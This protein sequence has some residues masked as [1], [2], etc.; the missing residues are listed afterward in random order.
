PAFAADMPVRTPKPA[1]KAP[2]AAPIYN[3]TGPYAGMTVGYGWGDS[4]HTDSTAGASSGRF[5]IDG[6]LVGGTFGYNWQDGND[7]FGLETDISWSNIEGG[8]PALALTAPVRTELDWLG[9]IRARAG[10]TA[11]ASLFYVT[12][13]A[14]YGKVH[15]DMPTVDSGSDWRWGWTV[16]AG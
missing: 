7:V 6:W 10:F 4:R 9:T 3:W 16:G 5:D 8:N 15:A 12:G 2:Y 1:Y 13:G 11:D 14:A